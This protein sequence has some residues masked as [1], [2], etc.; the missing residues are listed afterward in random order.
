MCHPYI[1]SATALPDNP[2][3]FFL[4]LKQIH[5]TQPQDIICDR[6]GKRDNFVQFFKIE[7][8]APQ[9]RVSPQL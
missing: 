4:G 1:E 9:G 7:V 6:Y 5:S 2:T 3:I 8:L